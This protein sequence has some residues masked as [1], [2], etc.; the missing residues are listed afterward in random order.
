MNLMIDWRTCW[1]YTTWRHQHSADK[2]NRNHENHNT[3]LGLQTDIKFNC[4]VLFLVISSIKKV[5]LSRLFEKSLIK[6]TAINIFWNIF[7]A[8]IG[9]HFVVGFEVHIKLSSKPRKKLS[10]EQAKDFSPR[11]LM[12]SCIWLGLDIQIPWILIELPIK[13]PC[14]MVFFRYFYGLISD[15]EVFWLPTI[16]KNFRNFNFHLKF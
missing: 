7:M 1:M 12:I 8:V 14:F 3:S 2:I 5:K 9:W 13:F 4:F 11:K 10:F 16:F 6:I 15:L